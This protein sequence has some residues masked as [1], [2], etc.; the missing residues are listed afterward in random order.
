MDL[1]EA[2][3][4]IGELEGRVTMLTGERDAASERAAHLESAHAT[5]DARL[6][7]T[8]GERDAAQRALNEVNGSLAE[9]LTL[10]RDHLRRALLAE[11][12]GRVVPELVTGEDEASLLASVEVA[13]QAYERAL[14]SARATIAGQAVPAGAPSVRTV[15]ASAGLTP[16][17]MIESG[18]RK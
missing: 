10:G 7:E 18:L 11:H 6:A 5:L 14:A 13:H 3:A 12:A 15:V 16:L 8:A 1:E 2:L 17:E 4:Q 9:A